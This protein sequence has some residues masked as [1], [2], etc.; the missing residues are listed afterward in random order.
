[1]P[2]FFVVCGDNCAAQEPLSCSALLRG[3]SGSP[4]AGK[5][6]GSPGRCCRARWSSLPAA[7]SWYSR[8]WNGQA[9]AWMDR[10]F[11]HSCCARQRGGCSF[12]Y[13]TGYLWDG[14]PLF[15]SSSVHSGA[16]S[17][18]LDTPQG[19]CGRTSVNKKGPP[20]R[21]RWPWISRREAAAYSPATAFWCS[22]M[23]LSATGW[24]ASS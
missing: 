12:S 16:Y 3:C 15:H 24:G 20:A 2:S 10:P 19:T 4:E 8:L 7:V 1:M 14:A 23:T 11:S 13:G 18:I 22:A 5:G 17:P 21:S 6:R 9:P